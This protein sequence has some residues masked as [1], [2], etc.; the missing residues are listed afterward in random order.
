MERSWHQNQVIST[1]TVNTIADGIAVRVP[2]PE[3]LK[4]LAFAVDDIIF[5]SDAQVIQAMRAYYDYERLVTEPAGVVSLAAAIANA[6]I[7]QGKTVVTLV[8][9]SNIDPQCRDEWLVSG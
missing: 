5:V 3:S 6:Q 2:V 9:G 8:S 7:D 4:T 1:D